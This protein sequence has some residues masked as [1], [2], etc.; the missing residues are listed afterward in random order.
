M[1]IP[2]RSRFDE[3]IEILKQAVRT[4]PETPG[5]YRMLNDRGD[6]LYVGKAKNLKRRVTNYTQ[7]NRLIK[8][9]QRMVAETR[10]LEVITTET[11]IKA[12]LL[13]INL[14]KSLR[15]RYNILLRDDKSFPY[16][17]LTGDHEFPQVMKHRGTRR[18]PGD[19]FGP[20]AS[21]FI[22]DRTMVGLQRAF[23]LRNCPD[24]IFA[25]RTRPCLQYHIKRCSAPCVGKITPEDYAA[26][27]DAA[28]NFLEGLQDDVIGRLK[29]QM[30]AA[31]DA[32][33]FEKA[34]LFRD[35]IR[36]LTS[37]NH[38]QGLSLA[39]IDKADIIA[40]YQEG[41]LNCVQVFFI[42]NGQNYGNQAYYPQADAEED[43]ADILGSFIMQFY[44]DKPPPPLILTHVTP[45]EPE[46]LAD[47][48]SEV[49]GHKITLTTPIRGEKRALIEHVYNNARDAHA[50]RLVEAATQQ[51]LRQG[52]ADLFNLPD[53]P[54]RIEVYDNSHLMGTNALGAM[55]VAG[56]EGFLKTA[57]RKF[58]IKDTETVP[59][60]DY[61]MMREML[62]RR[63]KRALAEDPDRQSENWPD[64]MLIDGGA[65]Q[66]SVS[67]AVMAEL[68]LSDIPLV[69]ISKGPDRHAGREQFHRFDH[70]TFQLPEQDPV[71]FYLQ[72]LRD[73]AHRFAIDN[74]RSKRKKE[75]VTS[76]LDA[77]PGIGPSRK[78]ALLL[79]FGSA[80][81]VQHASLADIIAVPGITAAIAQKIFDFFH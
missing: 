4:L 41:G 71:L 18:R 46:L 23:Q 57:Y 39:G 6:V 70:P 73:E 68:G 14:I 54:R 35:R 11:E 40:L 8:R 21:S 28:R 20:F 78:R 13:E 36:A 7:A 12:L 1:T 72:R 59:G 2:S 61:A 75:M 29:Q 16:L 30:V 48:L 52:I 76:P 81:A 42:R 31:S 34:G 33:D 69:A 32:L 74:H 55:I 64:L 15:P 19:Y 26:Q 38:Q 24:T 60:D 17:F 9:H 58:N 77:I 79:H 43:P 47:A 22:V 80:K 62:T 66:L 65:G 27:C 5:V 56:P 25:N 50:R 53:L 63:F 10:H 67:V 45:S 51:T 3:G 37:L 49:A 44:D